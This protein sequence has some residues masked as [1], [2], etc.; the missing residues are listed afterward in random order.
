MGKKLVKKLNLRNGLELLKRA[1]LGGIGRSSMG[2]V[3]HEPQWQPAGE[4]GAMTMAPRPVDDMPL[5]GRIVE[6]YLK[7]SA[8]D[9]A[10]GNSQWSLFFEN[11]RNIHE[12]VLR[13]DLT[14]FGAA[15]ADPAHNNIQYGFENIRAEYTQ[16]CLTDEV[17][18]AGYTGQVFESLRRL[19]EAVGAI[20]LD[21]P[22]S[23]DFRSPPQYSIE[24]L[25]ETLDEAL[26]IAVDFPNPYPHEFGLRTSRGVAGYRAVQALYQAWRIKE[27]LSGRGKGRVIEIGAG[28]GRTAYYAAKLGIA[29]YTIVDLPFTALSSSY[30]LGR[31]LGD[32]AIS[33][34]GETDAGRPIRVIPPAAFLA[35]IEQA[36]LV[37]NFDS[38]TEI[39]R[40][41]AERY[42]EHIFLNT[43][44]FLSVNHEANP[45]R[46]RDFYSNR[47]QEFE[48]ERH[49]YWMRAGYVEEFIQRPR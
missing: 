11:S 35:S 43:D 40:Q 13:R 31:T 26:G 19:A 37:V 4:L 38:F 14:A 27:L 2:S 48:V 16:Q 28:L 22:E 20:P 15:L 10:A 3:P 29:H 21:N 23:H 36:D 39:D 45:I 44:R 24:F 32:T 25:I 30:F 5:V 47:H 18:L 49:P 17:A 41:A 12:A 42:W 46:V 9:S 7:S 1:T 34:F 6:S 8:Q 33:L